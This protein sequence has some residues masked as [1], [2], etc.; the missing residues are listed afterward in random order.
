M[1][2]FHLSWARICLEA[3]KLNTIKTSESLCSDAEL[4]EGALRVTSI[5]S[6][7]TAFIA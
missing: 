4:N 1:M 5:S 7:I 3:M 6:S 2:S